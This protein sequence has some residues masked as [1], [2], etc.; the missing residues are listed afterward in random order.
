MGGDSAVRTSTTRSTT[1]R[2]SPASKLLALPAPNSSSGT[3]TAASA[4]MPRLKR[5]TAEEMAAKR[6]RGECYKCSEKFTR[7]HF[8]VCRMKGIYLIELDE[9]DYTVEPDADTPQI[10]LHAITGISSVETMKLRVCLGAASVDALVDSGS[11]HSF[12]SVATAGRLHLLPIHRPG[13][14]QVTVANGDRVL[15]T[16][17]CKDVRFCIDKE[18]FVMDFFI[19]PLAGYEMVLGVHWLRTLGPILW[20]FTNACMSCWWDDHRTVWQGILSDTPPSSSS[21][22]TSSAHLRDFRHHVATIIGSTY[23]RTPRQWPSGCIAI[24]NSSRM[25]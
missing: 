10:S 25:S 13:L 11:T 5:L 4:Q 6:E 19:I 1:S 17:V 14:L 24:H 15:S 23:C 20:D 16:G 2:T 18:E 3:T 21:S 8:K 9:E 7:D 12:I 22:T